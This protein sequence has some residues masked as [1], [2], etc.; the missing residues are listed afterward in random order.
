M[1]ATRTPRPGTAR[2]LEAEVAE[3]ERRRSS[4]AGAGSRKGSIQRMRALKEG[5]KPPGSRRRRPSARVTWAGRRDSLRNAGG[6][7]EGVAGEQ[8]AWAPER[9]GADA[10]GGGDEEDIARWSPLDRHP[11]AKMLQAE[12]QKLLAMEDRLRERV[13]ARRRPSGGL[14][15][16]PPGAGGLA[17]ENRP[18]LVLVPGPRGREDRVGRRW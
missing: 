5:S 12:S 13:V 11:V 6:P 17:D 14:E 1:S 9:T 3:L 2:A 4:S 16:H 7:G 18:P 10:E 8:A 15:R